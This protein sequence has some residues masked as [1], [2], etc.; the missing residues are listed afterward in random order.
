[1]ENMMPG[2][3][4]KPIEQKRRTGNPGQKPLPQVGTL[5]ALP[6]ADGIPPTLRPLM[7]EG[8]RL[9]NRVW[10]EGA[11]WLSP[12]TDIELVQMLAETMEERGPLR[13]LVLS[14]EGEWR[15]RVALRTIDDQIKSLLSALGFTPV[16]RTRM[17]VAEVRGL[18][19]LEAL[20]ARAA[21]R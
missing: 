16:D 18:S 8:Q 5:I 11:V 1:M 12:N 6:A 10:S 9:W 20:Q 13:D 7:N 21:Q 4:P 14:G 2:P 17:G 3:P 15:D 19:K